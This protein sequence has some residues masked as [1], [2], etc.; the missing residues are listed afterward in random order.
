MSV[1][2]T[3]NFN[4][5]F[6][7]FSGADNKADDGI[8][9][10]YFAHFNGSGRYTVEAVVMNNGRA[11]IDLGSQMQDSSAPRLPVLPSNKGL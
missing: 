10:G 4:I 3:E 1:V 7:L 9:S 11:R 2:A 6:P 8:Y 5:F